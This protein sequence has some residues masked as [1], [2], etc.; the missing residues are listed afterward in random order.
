MNAQFTKALLQSN[1]G[2]AALVLRVPVGLILAAHG[3]QKLFG[4]FGGY[5]LEGTGQWLASIGLEPGYLMALLA[6][7]AEFFGGLALVLGLLTRPAAVVAAFT[8]LVA[9]FAVHIGN[10]LFMANN[11]YEY[12]LTLFAA[13]VA[14][15]IQGAGR[16]AVDNLLH[17][18]S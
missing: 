5:G 18:E 7:G 8:M 4:W 15:A 1:G 6:G 3:A 2:F 14:L 9:I 12:A 10:G 13:T 16:F 11:G 17:K